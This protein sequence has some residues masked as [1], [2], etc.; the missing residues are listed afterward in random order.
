[1]EK[2]YKYTRE[3]IA[4]DL[5]RIKTM[6]Y[7]KNHCDESKFNELKKIYRIYSNAMK[8]GSFRL[9]ITFFFIYPMNAPIESLALNLN[10]D[11]KKIAQANLEIQ[12]FLYEELNNEKE[13]VA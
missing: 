2:I 8:N 13:A 9:F 3:Q 4:Y 6:E 5:E 12:D 11:L 7:V 10:W 1:M